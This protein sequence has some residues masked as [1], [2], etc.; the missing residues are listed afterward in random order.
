MSVNQENIVI[1]GIGMA[2]PVGLT[3]K[4][5]YYAVRAGVSM[6][7]E[8]KY[9]DQMGEP[10]VMASI[11][12]DCFDPNKQVDD[13]PSISVNEKLEAR[14][15]LAALEDLFSN[16]SLKL[17]SGHAKLFLGW[18][19]DFNKKTIPAVFESQSFFHFQN[20]FHVFADGR[21]SGLK[22]LHRAYQAIMNSECRIAVVGASDSY[23]RI[24]L[25]NYLDADG[26]IRNSA[27]LDGFIPGEGACF[28]LITTEKLALAKNWPVY[29]RVANSD[30]GFE[31]G[32]LGSDKPYRGE[33]LA[34]CVTQVLDGVNIGAIGQLYSSMNGEHF[35]FKEIG[36]SILRNK[37]RFEKDYSVIHPA[38]CIGDTGAASGL[39]MAGIAALS[40]SFEHIEKPSLLYASS[41]NGD[42]ATV[43]LKK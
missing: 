32:H 23:G 29:A 2:T 14:I 42:R 39:I 20:P 17:A 15:A 26:R 35:W 10:F 22:A 1:S 13:I 27:N 33:G 12:V 37:N 3:A 5:T 43:V 25:L 24:P 31:E 38:D 8:S 19:S 36:T 11:P 30:I 21:A 34:N 16:E 28:L 9:L 6:F 40:Y 18:N 7:E 41:D 4:D